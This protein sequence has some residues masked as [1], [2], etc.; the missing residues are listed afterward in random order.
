[1]ASH[2]CFELFEAASVFLAE[3]VLELPRLLTNSRE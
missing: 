1:M 2:R 3:A